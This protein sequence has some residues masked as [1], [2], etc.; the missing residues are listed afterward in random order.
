MLFGEY[1]KKWK[2]RR[3]P[4]PEPEAEAE[5]DPL[6]SIFRFTGDQRGIL[7]PLVGE[8]TAAQD[9]IDNFLTEDSSPE[10]IRDAYANL[11]DAETALF[12]Q[13]VK[14]ILLATDITDEAR[15]RALR[16]ETQIFDREIREANDDLVDAFEDIGL[17]LVQALTFT[18]G[19]L[20]DT[21][22]ATQQIPT[23]VEAAAAETAAEVDPDDPLVPLR[24]NV[25]LAA[26]QVRRARTG[27]GQATSESDFET[28]RLVLIEK[29]NDAFT[30]QITLLD[31]L[32]LSEA[33]YQDR[34]EDAEDTR[35]AAL[36]RATTA[37]NTFAEARIKGEEDAAEAA[38]DAADEAIKATERATAE[39]LRITERHQRA[40]DDLRDDAVDAESDRLQ[41][42]EDLTARHLDRVLG[43]Q[44]GFSRDLDDLRADRIDD[45]EDATLN[46]QRNLQD[47]QNEYARELFGDSI[48]FAD[49]TSEQQSRLTSN[50]GLSVETARLRTRFDRQR[51]D[52]DL[53]RDR[54]RQDRR[55]EFGTLQSGSAGEAFYRQQLESG[56]LT[57]DNL[58]EQLFGR[59]GLDDFTSFGRGTEDAQASLAQGII[60]A[61]SNYQSFLSDN[62]TALVALTGVLDGTPQPEIMMF[63]QPVAAIPT[64]TP[65]AATPVQTQNISEAVAS[66]V[67][68]GIQQSSAQPIANTPAERVVIENLTVIV[69]LDDGATAKLE[70]RLATRAD[71]GLSVLDV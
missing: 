24:S 44:L 38:Q 26:N 65:G 49:L 34:F 27:L 11:T 67:S 48:S 60:D 66:G 18:S 6:R 33:D 21:A 35:D 58:I 57:D 25:N 31:A 46:Y 47:L 64:L 3:K 63:E 56:E 1:L 19:V 13:K 8:V 40:I 32:G 5:A 39:N 30:T 12:N 9:F 20:R 15:G 53:G 23:E 17:Q 68:Q 54:D 36:T 29:V 16:V 52:L 41:R 14:F 51:F 45:T 62:T 50:E 28:R 61:T 2:Q 55:T 42:I 71:Q 37:V 59:Q 69:Q 70:G 22:I 4:E 10:E 43:L 7:A